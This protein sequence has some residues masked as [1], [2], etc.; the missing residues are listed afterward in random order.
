[1]KHFA[2][3]NRYRLADCFVNWIINVKFFKCVIAGVEYTEY[4]NYTVMIDLI[5]GQV[6][7]Q[8]LVMGE[9]QL[10]NHHSAI[11]LDLVAPQVQVLKAGALSQRL[12]QILCALTFN[13]IALNVKAQKAVGSAQQITK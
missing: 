2:E 5:I 7:R 3:V 4:T 10:S 11:R 8:E 9:Q 6:K 12:S 1:L 13:F